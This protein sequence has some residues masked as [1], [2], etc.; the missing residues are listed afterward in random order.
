M[1]QN[2]L[3]PSVGK[4][5]FETVDRLHESSYLNFLNPILRKILKTIIDIDVI[6][7]ML[8]LSKCQNITFYLYHRVKQRSATLL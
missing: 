8:F 6:D 5:L 1:H 4:E 7:H 2:M 3:M